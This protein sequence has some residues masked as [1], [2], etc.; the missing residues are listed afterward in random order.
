MMTDFLPPNTDVVDT[1]RFQSAG[2]FQLI[3]YSLGSPLNIGW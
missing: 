3:D 2:P 1:C